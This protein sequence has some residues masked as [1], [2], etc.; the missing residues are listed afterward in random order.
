[1][2][3]L[4]T[5]RTLIVGALLLLA[6][7]SAW[8][9]ALPVF[10]D[11]GPDAAAYGA[12]EHYPVGTPKTM[13]SQST[14]V[15]ALSHNEDVRP[16]HRVAAPA[17]P[18]SLARAPEELALRYTHQ[19]QTYTIADYLDRN[20]ATGLLVLQDRT[21]LY[22][23]YRYART[24]RDRFT[25]QS[26]AKSVVAMLIGVAVGE[27][28]IRSLDDLVQS[29]L[30][31]TENTEIGRTPLRALLHMASGLSFREVY[32]GKDDI[33]RL[34]R[35]LMQPGSPGAIALLPQFDHRVAAP[36]TVFNYSGLD[37]EL[38]GLVLARATGMTMASY[39]EQRIWS[40]IGAEASAAWIIDAKGAEVAYCCLSATLR[41]WGR[42]GALLAA[43]G[44]WDGRQIIPRDYLR[45]ATISDMPFLAPG[46]ARR[47]GLGYGYQVWLLPGGRRAFALRGIY[48]QIILIDPMTHL[49][50]VHTAVRPTATSP[51]A[52]TELLSLWAA[53]VEQRG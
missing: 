4:F 27:G 49:V 3:K 52:E 47:N 20:P 30:P 43:D 38:L 40:A 25:T 26:I 48:G 31:E 28:K 50:L 18:S 14:L 1:M 10:S 39:L 53:L 23:H 51:T 34:G 35:G 2:M 24:D 41:D 9:E 46:G 36:G 29:Y 22:E 16:N 45:D 13:G 6:P 21:I 11:T 44:V 17:Q 7:A 37:T 32:N 8:C 12:T 19:G 33:A 5:L 15:G 42:F